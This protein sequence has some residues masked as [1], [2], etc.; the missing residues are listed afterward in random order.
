MSTKIPYNKQTLDTPNP[1]ARFSHKA[2]YKFSLNK[3]LDYLNPNG[4][5]LDFGCG[6]G[7]FLRKLAIARPEA[8]LYGFDPESDQDATSY[9]RIG[10]LD[11]LKDQSVDVVCC[12]ET[13]EHLYAN[14]KEQFYIDAKRVLSKNGKII[15]SVPIIGGPM[16]LVKDLNHRIL[17]KRRSEYSLKELLLASFFFKVALRPKNLRITHKGFN[18][19]DVERETF[20]KFNMVEK[21]YSPFPLL[22]WFLNSQLFLVLSI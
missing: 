14:E 20:T 19:R 3:V 2:R 8:V 6:D 17:Y 13:F 15:V 21:L 22:P 7:S 10:T 12:F 1:I 16:L 9:N 4:I 11:E 5:L 18:F